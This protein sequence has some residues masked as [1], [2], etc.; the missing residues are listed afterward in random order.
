MSPSPSGQSIAAQKK[1][2]PIIDYNKR[3]CAAI[4]KYTSR[5]IVSTRSDPIGAPH[6]RRER[7]RRGEGSGVRATRRETVILVAEWRPTGRGRAKEPQM[8]VVGP[9]TKDRTAVVCRGNDARPRPRSE[10]LT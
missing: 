7:A 6:C 8:R 1:A 10:T 5:F 9:Q 3:T 4:P 2:H